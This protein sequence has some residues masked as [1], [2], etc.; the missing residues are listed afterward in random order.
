MS[1]VNKIRAV[2]NT[3]SPSTKV[4]LCAIILILVIGKS[5]H[6]IGSYIGIEL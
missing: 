6:G 3:T 4:M 5:G 2:W 1:L